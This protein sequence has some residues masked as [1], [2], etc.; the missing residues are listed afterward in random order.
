MRGACSA[1]CRYERSIMLDCNVQSCLISL[2]NIGDTDD[3]SCS[4]S[5]LNNTSSTNRSYVMLDFNVVSSI[6]LDWEVDRCFFVKSIMIGEL[7]QNVRSP[8]DATNIGHRIIQ[9]VTENIR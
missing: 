7:F 1:I 4:I 8:C 5:M 3:S 6:M 2:F 9:S